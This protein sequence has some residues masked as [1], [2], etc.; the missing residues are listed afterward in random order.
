MDLSPMANTTPVHAPWMTKVEVRARLRVS[1]AL[2]D[3]GST[4]PGIGLLEKGE[5]G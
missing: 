1:S 4:V 3:V 2:S 5:R